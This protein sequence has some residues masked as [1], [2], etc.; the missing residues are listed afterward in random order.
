VAR[1]ELD[2]DVAAPGLAGD[3]RAVQREP[4]DEGRQV[5]GDRR[6]VVR[7]VGLR[8]AAMA[9]QVDAG[10]GVPVGHQA[11]G[12]AIPEPRVRG[13]AVDEQECRERVVLPRGWASAAGVQVSIASSTPSATGIRWVCILGW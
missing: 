1:G 13:E 11:L 4:G 2:D 7:A 6:H 3:D 12:D 10:N 5:V 9:A 8:G